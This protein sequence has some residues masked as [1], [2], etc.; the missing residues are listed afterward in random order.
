M[1]EIRIGFSDFWDDFDERNNLFY[2]LLSKHYTITLSEQPDYLFC[3][4]FGSKHLCYDCI[5]IFYTGENQAPDFNLVDYAIGFD[6]ISFGDRFFRL[7]NYYFYESDF[8]KMLR[9]H[10]VT[11]DVLVRKTDFCSFVYSNNH[12]SPDRKRFYDLLSAYKTVHSGGRYLNNVGGA[13]GDKLAFQQ[14][15]KFC[16][17]F[18]NTSHEGYATEKIV[19]AF[20]AQAIPIYWGDTTIADTFNEQAFINC[21]RYASFGEV[22]NQIKRIDCDDTLYLRML[23]QPALLHAAD[24]YDTKMQQLEQYL[25]HI[26]EQPIHEAQRFSRNYWA[27]RYLSQMRQKETLYQR[28]PRGIAERIYKQTLWKA[29]RRSKLFWTIDRIVKSKGRY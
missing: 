26:V 14:K 12:A 29:R 20:A 18:E 16:I 28:S 1:K 21:H 5:K 11:A 27:M 9:K 10:E 25:C 15:H 4:V 8:R 22:V 13:V 19:Q 3:S 23:Q 2:R 17:A 24:A 6:H 7:P